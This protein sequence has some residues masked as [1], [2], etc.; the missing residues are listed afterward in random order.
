MYH[1]VFNCDDN[2][3]KYTAVLIANIIDMTNKDCV[4]SKGFN[5]VILREHNPLLQN[6]FINQNIESNFPPPPPIITAMMPK[7]HIKMTHTASTLSLI[8]LSQVI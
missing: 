7:P 6:T 1:I 4:V 3:V 5:G 8:K 2:Y